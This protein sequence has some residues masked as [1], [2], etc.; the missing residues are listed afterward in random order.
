MRVRS[1]V[2]VAVLVSMCLAPSGIAAPADV[3]TLASALSKEL[4]GTRLDV[5][6]EAEV[7]ELLERSLALVRGSRTG[8]RGSDDECVNLAVSI[9]AKQF[10]ASSALEKS[11]A[12]CRASTDI[13]IL[14]LGYE[15]YAKQFQPTSALETSA[16][17]AQ[18]AELAGKSELLEFAKVRLAKTFQES[19]ALEAAAKLVAGTPRDGATCVQRAYETYSK[20]FDTQAALNKAFGACAR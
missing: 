13:R 14:R 11:M 4:G 20:Q 19:A 2:A 7:R 3:Q 5:A 16:A 18:R 12:L 6:T 17:L 15:I 8:T 10:E 9:Y 1:F